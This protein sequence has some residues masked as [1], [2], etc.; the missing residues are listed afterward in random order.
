MISLGIIS[1]V[2]VA[3]QTYTEDGERTKHKQLKFHAAENCHNAIKVFLNGRGNQ[4][5]C[6]TKS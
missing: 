2:L 3:K 5:K 1:S 6:Q 4:D